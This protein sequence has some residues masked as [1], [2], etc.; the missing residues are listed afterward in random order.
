LD[1]GIP[2]PLR[3]FLT[4]HQVSTAYEPGWGCLTNGQLLQHAESNGF[5]VLVTTDQNLRHQQ[6]LSSRK[7][8]IVVLGCTSWPRIAKAVSSVVAA[9]E[10]ST[11]NGYIE[12]PIP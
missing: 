1:Q 7:I 4:E 9:I 6:N 10:R 8:A 11:S 2:A 12:V 5:E 3:K